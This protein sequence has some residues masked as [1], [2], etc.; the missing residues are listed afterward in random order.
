[1]C[2]GDP[3]GYPPYVF[4]PRPP[5]GP[6]GPAGPTFL[7]PSPPPK[8]PTQNGTISVSRRD[9]FW[10]NFKKRKIMC[11]DFKGLCSAHMCTD[12][13]SRA[14]NC[15]PGGF[16]HAVQHPGVGA[17]PCGRPRPLRVP[18]SP[19]LARENASCQRPPQTPFR[20]M[21]DAIVAHSNPRTQQTAL[22]SPAASHWSH[23]SHRS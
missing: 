3:R 16:L 20:G 17:P 10:P 13:F 11:N 8:T 18:T 23:R 15:A 22:R 9:S 1:M 7:P 6:T 2:T 12:I 5:T 4:P 21:E 19:F 14:S